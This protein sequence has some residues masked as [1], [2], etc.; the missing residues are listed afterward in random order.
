MK[1]NLYLLVNA[2]TAQVP[3]LLSPTVDT[4]YKQADTIRFRTKAIRV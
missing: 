1:G 3:H 2:H 4:A